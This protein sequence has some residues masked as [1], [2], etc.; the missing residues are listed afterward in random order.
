ML[1]NKRLSM[2]AK[3][4][5]IALMATSGAGVTSLA[6]AATTTTNSGDVVLHTNPDNGNIYMGDEVNA[7]IANQNLSNHYINF[8]KHGNKALSI[9][10]TQADFIEGG[11]KNDTTNTTLVLDG[12]TLKGVQKD[13]NYD[14]HPEG[15]GLK[16]KN[17]ASGDSIY[18]DRDDKGILILSVNNSTLNGDI[19]AENK[20]AKHALIK[21][22]TITGATR[23]KG[24][25]NELHFIHSHQKNSAN[26]GDAIAIGEAGQS[27]VFIDASTFEG[28]INIQGKETQL[29]IGQKS[30][31]GGD[32]K[33]NDSKQTDLRLNDSSVKNIILSG[34]GASQVALN[35]SEVKGNLDSS[36]STGSTDVAVNHSTVDGNIT[37]GK[38]KNRVQL[39][40]HSEVKGDISA[41][42]NDSELRI[43]GSSSHRGAVHNFTHI[44]A[45]DH[46]KLDTRAIRNARIDLTGAS[47][48]YASELS[49][50][51]LVMDSESQFFVNDALSGNN[52]ATVKTL[53]AATSEGEHELGHWTNNGGGSMKAQFANG[54]QQ[55][56]ARKGAWN[57]DLTLHGMS[58]SANTT[59]EMLA[60]KRSTLASD[61][62]GAQ[63]NLNAAQRSSKAISA[64]VAQRFSKID[65][66]AM[67]NQRQPGA[68]VWA[69]YIG[70]NNS[71]HGDA[72]YHGKLEGTML[73]MDWTSELADDSQLTTGLAFGYTRTKVADRGDGAEFHNR[74]SGRYYTLYSGWQKNL[75]DNLGLFAN[76]NL[77]WGD[78]SYSLKAANVSAT[79][80]GSKQ[81]LNG[82][83][84]GN[85]YS[86]ELRTG[87]AIKPLQQLVVQPYIL[88]GWNKTDAHSFSDQAGQFGHNQRENMYAGAGLRTTVHFALGSVKLMPW[89]EV[90]YIA[91][92]TDNSRFSAMDYQRSHGK[93]LQAAA[94]SIG[95]D[96]GITPNLG[97]TVKVSAS[98]GNRS[99]DTAMLVGVNYHF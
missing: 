62:K 55:A 86:A 77:T 53:S 88:A 23:F 38:G 15:H 93:K 59:E 18:F 25:E 82:G 56:T 66:D 67:F 47:A 7:S 36:A 14:S 79:T 26:S 57:Y 30:G 20:A 94:L 71:Q 84:H 17:Y 83:T 43:D 22:S 54:S 19:S 28:G 12:A 8:S 35:N 81:Q 52:S 85:S 44:Y 91:D 69:D 11:N 21:N 32:I 41:A 5:I 33:L 61:V 96:A 27:K 64:S 2:I 48:L 37:L 74:V 90:N 13:K 89:A 29:D 99:S 46:S 58:R 65:E 49:S 97:A 50:S 60:V 45:D 34:S 87:V 39:T 40:N 16:N 70:Q 98:E 4:V 51:E 24:E 9:K 1:T 10:N 31:I 76:G 92:V 3:G 95:A 63:A 72:G 73:G 68:N 42:G 80:D 75:G 6:N 78:M